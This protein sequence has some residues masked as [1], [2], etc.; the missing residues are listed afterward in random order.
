MFLF[1][2]RGNHLLSLAGIKFG[3]IHVLG[4]TTELNNRKCH[5][6]IFNLPVKMLRCYNVSMLE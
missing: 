2:K 5:H 4:I 1:G 6:G 3:G